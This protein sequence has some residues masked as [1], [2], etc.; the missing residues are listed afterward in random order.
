MYAV[1]GC[2]YYGLIISSTDIVAHK[3]SIVSLFNTV[4]AYC[5]SDFES[6]SVKLSKIQDCNS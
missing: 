4:G 1:S 2:P 3:R 5:E 6:D